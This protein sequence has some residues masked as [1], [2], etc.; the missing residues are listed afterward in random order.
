MSHHASSTTRRVFVYGSLRRGQVNH[1]LLAGARYLGMHETHPAYTMLDLGPYPGVISGGRARVLGEVYAIDTTTFARLDRL[2][3]Y[4]LEYDRR[5]IPT[6]WGQSWIYLYRR[7][8]GTEP[9][10]VS[11]DWLRRSL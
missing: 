7:A 1:C 2:E 3:G 5:L 11:G 6:L 9:R 10:I 8:K 4:P